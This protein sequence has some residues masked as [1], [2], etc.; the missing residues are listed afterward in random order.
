M[1]QVQE[2]P[3][4]VQSLQAINA[5]CFSLAQRLHCLQGPSLRST[6]VMSWES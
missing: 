4:T 5:S 1:E 3:R 6:L 2:L